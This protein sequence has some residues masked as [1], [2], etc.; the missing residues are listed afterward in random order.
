MTVAEFASSPLN[1]GSQ[2]DLEEVVYVRITN[3]DTNHDLAIALDPSLGTTASLRLEPGMSF[4]MG[5]PVDYF[6]DSE[7]IP[8]RDLEKIRL[9]SLGSSHVDA[10]V[11]VA[12]T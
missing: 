2:F 7:T 9:R 8:F 12:S 11:V 10:E 3:L 4:M 1:S 6:A 5:S